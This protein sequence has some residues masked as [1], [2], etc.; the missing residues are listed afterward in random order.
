MKYRNFSNTG[1]KVSELRLGCWGLGGSWT[2]V[3]KKNALSILDKAFEKG[4]NFLDTSDSYGHGL[5]EKL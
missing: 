1:W 5:S 4:V 2:D 3:T